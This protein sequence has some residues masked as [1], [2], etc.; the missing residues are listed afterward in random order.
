M[1]QQSQLEGLSSLPGLAWE[2]LLAHSSHGML[3]RGERDADTTGTVTWARRTLFSLMYTCMHA[4]IH[5]CM[6]LIHSFGR[7]ISRSAALV[8]HGQA[9][10][11]LE[12]TIVVIRLPSFIHSFIHSFTSF[13]CLFVCLFV[14]SFIRLF[15]HSF[16]CSFIRSFV[17]SVI[18]SQ[19]SH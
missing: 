16:V 7:F 4:Y 2:A 5:S 9:V 14:C 3:A 18:P 12:K 10:I 15:V 13:V 11:S 6:S 8:K 19:I 1:S 17:Q